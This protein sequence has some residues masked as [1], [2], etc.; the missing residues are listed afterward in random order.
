MSPERE[1]V[2]GV[3]LDG[4]CAEF[5]AGLRPIAAEWLDVDEA[6]LPLEVSWGLEE[7]GVPQAP[8][9]YEDLHR[10]AVTQRDLFRTLRPLH[11]CP[12][13]LRRLSKAGIRIR[14]ITHR[15]VIKHFHNRAIEQTV[16]WLDNHGIPYW[17]LCFMRD[18]G[19]VGA[20]LYLEDSPANI[21]A[22]RSRGCPVIVFENSTNRS[23]APPRA[24]NWEQ[25][26]AQV[27]ERYERWRAC[28]GQE[29]AP[30]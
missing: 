15:L 23:F 1:F 20:D 12:A 4:V 8:G 11:G 29:S 24:A 28:P 10:F 17:D 22:L 6:C 14:I 9:G 27:L 25:A 16:E 7:W 18:K 21:Q 5:Y 30:P 19:A 3:D 26:Y 2:L 13:A